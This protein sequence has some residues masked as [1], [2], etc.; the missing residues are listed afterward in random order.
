MPPRTVA[1]SA[2]RARAGL[3]HGGVELPELLRTR[4][5]YMSG[6]DDERP[7]LKM[8][9]LSVLWPQTHAWTVGG[10]DL[11]MWRA[12]RP[13]IRH[14]GA[15]ERTCQA[16]ARWNSDRRRPRRC[17]RRSWTAAASGTIHQR[18]LGM[19]ERAACPL[20]AGRRDRSAAHLVERV[21]VHHV[22]VVEHEPAQQR[23]LLDRVQ[24]R[25]LQ[26]LHVQHDRRDHPEGRRSAP[27]DALDSPR[28]R[29]SAQ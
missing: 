10:R 18:G 7:S 19:R 21:V 2:T 16:A 25:C 4:S 23:V 12:A 17:S 3:P 11:S 29:R 15:S 22:N 20:A 1:P 8:T 6:S 24:R 9:G 14:G 27:L 5:S 28:E 26:P 13:S